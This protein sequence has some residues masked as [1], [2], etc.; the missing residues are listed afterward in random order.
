M[1]LRIPVGALVADY[2][3]TPA[4]ERANAISHGCGVLFSLAVAGPLLLRAA[5]AGTLALTT[6]AIFVASLLLTFGAST[7][8]HGSQPGRLRRVWLGLD[9][10][11]VYFLI[12][13]TWTP[14]VL[15]T[16]T[17]W[18]HLALLGAIWAIAIVGTYLRLFRYTDVTGPILA[19]YL[20]A[21]WA[22]VFLIPHLWSVSPMLV[23]LVF[24][25]GLLYTLGVV[26]FLW[27]SL[28]FNHLYWHL[29]SL[30]GSAAHV[31]AIWGV[32]LP[33]VA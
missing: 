10:I 5:D 29:F 8:Y 30:G 22:G 14:V 11:A 31:V 23:L 26:F 24:G 15:L 2:T 3:E 17:H 6:V 16:W 9:H 20:A 25:G 4:E 27:R 33:A 28:R 12:A 18:F 13:G 1:T 21:G 32:L 19:L 7:L